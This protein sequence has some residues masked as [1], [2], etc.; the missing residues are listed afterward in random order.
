MPTGM[1]AAVP[2]HWAELVEAVKPFL[3]GLRDLLKE[4]LVE[5]SIFGSTARGEAHPGSDVDVLV[6]V[7]GGREEALKVIDGVY[8]SLGDHWI[9]SASEGYV[10]ELTVV[11]EDEWK[12]M[13]KEG[14]S[15]PMSVEGEKFTVFRRD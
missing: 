6:I 15:F 9:Q 11:G 4:S 10:V 8:S 14:F 2:K 7:R 1:V 5:I 3:D 13:L 12:V